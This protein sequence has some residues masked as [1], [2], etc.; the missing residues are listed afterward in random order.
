MRGR[1]RERRGRED[2]CA[3]SCISMSNLFH[4]LLLTFAPGVE[5]LGVT[6]QLATPKQGKSPRKKSCEQLV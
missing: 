6:V 4:F 2:S 3:C 5:Q 1:G